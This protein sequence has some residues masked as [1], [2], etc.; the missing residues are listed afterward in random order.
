MEEPASK[1]VAFLDRPG[2]NKVTKEVAMLAAAAGAAE[3]PAT[4]DS[5]LKKDE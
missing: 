3:Q 1:I 5:K 2:G 4:K